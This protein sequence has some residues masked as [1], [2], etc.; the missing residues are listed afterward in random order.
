MN[1]RVKIKCNNTKE[2]DIDG[3]EKACVELKLKIKEFFEQIDSGLENERYA[4]VG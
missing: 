1:L 4:A 3:L 2:V